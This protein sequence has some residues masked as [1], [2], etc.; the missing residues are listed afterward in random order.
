MSG[1]LNS[2]G[3]AGLGGGVV[4]G[5]ATGV[6]VAGAIG[7]LLGLGQTDVTLGGFLFSGATIAVPAEMRWGTQQRVVRHV[8]PGG[9]VKINVM[10]VD[11]PPISF[12]GVFDGPTAGDRAKA[13]SRLTAAGKPLTL[14]WM[15]RIFLVVI[16][17]FRATDT[18]DGWVAYDIHCEV[19]ADADQIAGPPAPP[20]L[21]Q[22]IKADINAAMGL[23][24]QIGTVVSA[25]Q[26]AMLV[27]GSFTLGTAPNAALVASIAAFQASQQEVQA[28]AES[29]LSS[30]GGQGA[31]GAS[32]AVN[33]LTYGATLA[34]NLAQ[35]MT[36]SGNI[37]RAITNL[38][39]ASA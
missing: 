11:W 32:G 31:G 29:G 14:T 1:F 21:L 26:M 13:L 33:W 10:G 37:G 38:Q 22:Q 8:L 20:S 2:A 4:S 35:A 7:N 17:R 16:S 19:L 15:D 12:R 27:A 39:Q 36:A 25:V 9:T 6:G 34:G 18:T 28:S 30:L 23:V 24:G 3:T 5:L